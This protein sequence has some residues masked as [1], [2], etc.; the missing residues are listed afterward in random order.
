MDGQLKTKSK[1]TIPQSV[2]IGTSCREIHY[3]DFRRAAGEKK[4]NIKQKLKKAKWLRVPFCLLQC[5]VRERDMQNI[6]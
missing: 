1:M 3:T 4:Q 2:Q 5:G 6:K